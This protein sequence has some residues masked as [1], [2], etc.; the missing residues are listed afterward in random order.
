MSG[1]PHLRLGP[2]PLVAVVVPFGLM[3]L[4]GLLGFVGLTVAS[5]ATFLAACGWV[6]SGGRF[7][8]DSRDR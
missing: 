6:S 1:T 5:A 7:G 8:H 3:W 4:F 2:V